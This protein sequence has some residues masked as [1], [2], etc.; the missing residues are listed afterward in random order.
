[1][2]FCSRINSCYAVFDKHTKETLVV[3]YHSGWA[4]LNRRPHVPQT[5]TLTPALQPVYCMDHCTRAMDLC[6]RT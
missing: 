2:I 1:M 4:D 3:H 5:C 6:Q